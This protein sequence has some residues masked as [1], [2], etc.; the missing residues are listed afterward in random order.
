M[1]EQYNEIINKINSY[2]EVYV[3]KS[4][5]HLSKNVDLKEICNITSGKS[6]LKCKE[7]DIPI[8]GANGLIGFTNEFNNYGD[9]LVTGRVGTLGS[10]HRYNNKV[11][12]SDNTLIMKSDY[13][14]FIHYYLLQNFNIS[15]L[16]KGSTQPLITQT[17]LG[18]MEIKIPHNINDIELVLGKMSKFIFSYNEKIK[19]LSLIK[20]KYLQKFFG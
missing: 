15:N 20:N 14:N 1:I 18:K 3:L 12:C 4:I 13:I 17:D 5:K 2:C 11:W 10:F 9:I 16:N 7:G 8:I 6:K 19:E